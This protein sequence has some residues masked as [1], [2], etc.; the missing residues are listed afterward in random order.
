MPAVFA[1]VS[2]PDRELLLRTNSPV[3]EPG[4]DDPQPIEEPE[5]PDPD[6]NPE[7]LPTSPE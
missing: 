1:T 2:N 4:S 5:D 3:E 7:E 6:E